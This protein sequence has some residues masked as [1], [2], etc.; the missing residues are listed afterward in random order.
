MMKEQVLIIRV[1]YED[2]EK[3]PP[4]TWDWTGLV[5]PTSRVEVLNHGGCEEAD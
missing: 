1:K 4:H 5:D 3:S 2:E